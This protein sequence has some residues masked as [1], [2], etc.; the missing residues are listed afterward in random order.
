MPR[1][2][3]FG[4]FTAEALAA[5]RDAGYQSREAPT[6]ALYESVGGT[7]EAYYMLSSGDWDALHIVTLPDADAAF[8][9]YKVAM[10]SGG[11]ERA[12]VQELRTLAEAD[13]ADK[14]VSTTYKAPGRS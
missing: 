1:Y 13:A 14:R 4:K 3:V 11:A 6:R 9:L 12:L 7:L 8:A 5:I 2:A 10:S